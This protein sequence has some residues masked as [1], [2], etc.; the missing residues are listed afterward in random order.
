MP[1]KI[2]NLAVKCYRSL[3]LFYYIKLAGNSPIIFTVENIEKS[4]IRVYFEQVFFCF[5]CCLKILSYID[6]RLKVCISQ[7]IRNFL[8]VGSFYFL[9]SESYFLKYEGNITQESFIF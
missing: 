2:P 1:F 5:C 7:N 9:S 4:M 3:L 8:R 6:L